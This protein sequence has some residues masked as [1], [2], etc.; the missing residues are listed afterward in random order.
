MDAGCGS[1]G[2]Y[3]PSLTTPAKKAQIFH[4]RKLLFESEIAFKSWLVALGFAA[5]LQAV[6]AVLCILDAAPGPK[7]PWLKYAL[8]PILHSGWVF[9]Q[10]V[11][12]LW[13]NWICSVGGTQTVHKFWERITSNWRILWLLIA[14]PV[15]S[16]FVGAIPLSLWYQTRTTF[17]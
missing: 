7:V 6:G 2:W 17:W 5:S 3:H 8:V 15:L 14:P 12:L 4:L 13:I 11:L 16:A 9:Y 10:I 1:K